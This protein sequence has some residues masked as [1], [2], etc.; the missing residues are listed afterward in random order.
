MFPISNAVRLIAAGVAMTAGAAHAAAGDWTVRSGAVWVVPDESTANARGPRA[1]DGTLT[2]ST[3]AVDNELQLG[4]TVSYALTAHLA[5]ELL[6]ATPF[7]HA[8]HIEGGALDGASLGEVEQLPP[9]LSLQYHFRPGAQLQPYVGFGLNA[10]LMLDDS[11]GADARAIGVHKISV[12]DSFG[13][14]GQIGADW[15]LGGGWLLNADARVID[16]DTTA[17]VR[18]DDGTTRV[19]VDL[20]PWVLAVGVGYRF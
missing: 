6:A 18:M 15:L 20:D 4:L 12:D 11:V 19:D 2:G 17:S 9:T 5:V 7:T 3:V 14:A 13:L 10:T 8:L 16:I 1:D